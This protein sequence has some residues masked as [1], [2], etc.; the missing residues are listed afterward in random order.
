MPEWEDVRDLYKGEFG[1]DDWFEGEGP[2]MNNLD[3]D[4]I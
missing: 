4:L 1:D 2:D 3:G